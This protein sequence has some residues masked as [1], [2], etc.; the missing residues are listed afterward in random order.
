MQVDRRGRGGAEFPLRNGFSHR[1]AVSYFFPVIDGPPRHWADSCHRSS[2]ASAT[3]ASAGWYSEL[4]WQ[5]RNSTNGCSPT[6]NG[7]HLVA[8]D[9]AWAGSSFRTLLATLL[10]PDCLLLESI[11]EVHSDQ[12]DQR[13]GR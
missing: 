6:C 4:R 2:P 7:A 8:A 9:D 12:H 13:I 1:G 11:A 5:S 10:L 3:I